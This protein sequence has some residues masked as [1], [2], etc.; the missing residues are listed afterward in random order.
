MKALTRIPFAALA[1]LIPCA[2]RAPASASPILS[3]IMSDPSA[4]ADARG[5]FLELGNPGEDSLLLD[6]LRIAVDGQSLILRGVAMAPGGHFL[7]CRDTLA[8]SNGGMECQRGW[9]GLSLPNS[10]EARIDLEWSGGSAGYALPA[11]L[12]GV[13]W[14]NTWEEGEGYRRFLPSAS[15]WGQGD[16]ATPGFRNGRSSL[17]PS[18][19]LAIAEMAWIR[20]GAGEAASSEDREYPEGYLGLRVESRGSAIPEGFSLALRLDSDWDGEAETPLDSMA[21]EMPSSGVAHLRFRMRPGFR[22]IVHARLGPD[23]D[24][25]ND[26]FL[27]PVETERILG[28]TEWRASPTGGEPEWVEIRN[29]TADSGGTGRRLE[30]SSAVFNGRLL[31][32]KAGGLEPGEFLIL[33]QSHAAFRE[34][35][36]AIKVRVMELPAWPALPNA[37]GALVLALCGFTVDSLV[38]DAKSAAAEARW[39]GAGATP[40]F[41]AAMPAESGWKLSGKVAAPGRPLDVEVFARG[42][43]GYS[44]GVFDLE[45]NRVK[46]LGGRGPG[47][48]RHSWQGEGGRGGPVAPGPYV[49]C[50]S[51][52]GGGPRWRAVIVADMQ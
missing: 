38:Y 11:P 33:T 27:L 9:P 30:L 19:D 18:R 22:G 5:E 7:I 32:A 4:V 15:P 12:A 17:R 42:P 1:L 21:T 34:R 49:L 24:P 6:S 13:S 3:E 35:F 46:D 50:L 2:F 25:A 16:M 23:G 36:G 8:A 20:A 39:S 51:M 40:G 45:G 10:R 52:D 43:G 48:H 44:L 47:R 28:F 31:G 14:E 41:E 29:Q 26:T 37:G